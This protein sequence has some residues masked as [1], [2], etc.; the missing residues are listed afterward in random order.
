M[1]K[2]KILS[3]ITGGSSLCEKSCQELCDKS[4]GAWKRV[5]KTFTAPMAAGYVLDNCRKNG[6]EGLW[7]KIIV[8]YNS[9]LEPVWVKVPQG[10]W[11]NSGG[12]SGQFLL[13]RG[14][15]QSF[16]QS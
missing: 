6:G 12:R 7:D 5:E 9:G 8:I 3:I 4:A 16:T 11:K 13:A 14:Q 2:I 10:P 1:E 15:R